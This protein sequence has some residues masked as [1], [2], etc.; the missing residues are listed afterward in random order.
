MKAITLFIYFFAKTFYL[1]S[2]FVC[3]I[4]HHHQVNGSS[5]P[6]KVPILQLNGSNPSSPN[7]TMNGPIHPV[8]G[9]N[10]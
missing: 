9:S 3:D 5:H 6:V 10:P 1:R 8:N 7:D 2:P 4:V